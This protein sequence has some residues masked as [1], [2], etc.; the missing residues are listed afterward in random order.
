MDACAVFAQVM[1]AFA[2]TIN[3]AQGQTL[4]RV[5]IYLPTPVFSHGQLYVAL[6]RNGDSLLTCVYVEQGEQQGDG[7]DGVAGMSTLNIVYLDVL[8]KAREALGASPLPRF[9]DGQRADPVLPTADLGPPPAAGATASAE[10]DVAALPPPLP[11]AF[12]AQARFPCSQQ[13]RQTHAPRIHLAHPL[14]SQHHPPTM[15]AEAITT[16]DVD[17]ME[18]QVHAGFL[19]QDFDEDMLNEEAWGAQIA[20][21]H[22]AVQ[23]MLAACDISHPSE[24][25]DE[26]LLE[27]ATTNARPGAGGWGAV[28][29]D[30]A[31]ELEE[32]R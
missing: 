20:A 17:E 23:P 4:D 12:P 30:Y 5:G 21:W 31:E 10:P 3:K 29:A 11:G 7:V 28:Y 18:T 15:Q 2:L 19:P 24:L 26:D 1:L 6:S 27:L 13:A 9:D 32:Q 14:P 25:Q 22:V 16:D 8:K